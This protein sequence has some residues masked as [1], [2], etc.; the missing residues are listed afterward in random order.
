MRLILPITLLALLSGCDDGSD[1]TLRGDCDPIANT[2]C[3][4]DD[5]CRV[6]GEGQTVCLPQATAIAS[7]CALDSCTPG[8]ACVEIEGLR[9]CHTLCDADGLCPD[10]M[11]CGYRLDGSPWY[12]CVPRCDPN[13]GCGDAAT[14]APTPV[15]S[16]PQ[17]V[18]DGDL[19]EGDQCDLDARCGH[20]M[21]C[22][23]QEGEARC[24]FLCSA[25]GP[26]CPGGAACDGALPGFDDV[27]FCP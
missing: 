6:V 13:Q 26:S 4:G 21:A 19:S 5:V 24:R 20:N 12:L 27:G 16:Y 14:C 17:C 15:V 25:D 10:G 23:Q 9:R 2:G 3:D 18:A 8:A 1:N 11:A 7:G 22:I